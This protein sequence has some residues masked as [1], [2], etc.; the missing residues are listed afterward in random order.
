MA[1]K[2]IWNNFENY[3]NKSTLSEKIFPIMYKENDVLVLKNYQYVPSEIL[4]YHFSS[5]NQKYFSN[6]SWIS[7]W[8]N[9]EEAIFWWLLELSERDSL[10]LTWLL[11]LN[12]SIIKKET[13]PE[14]LKNR[15][16]D[17][18]K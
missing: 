13:L 6:S 4:F 16:L 3:N 7:A 14:K 10:M 5:K 15:I 2:I 1:E 17:L 11:K 18:E 12:P 8:R 9:Y